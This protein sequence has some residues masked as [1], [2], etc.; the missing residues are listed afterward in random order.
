M[1]CH[2]SREHAALRLL[3]RWHTH[4]RGFRRV[5]GA[6]AS[7]AELRAPSAVPSGWTA[8]GPGGVSPLSHGGV[9]HASIGTRDSQSIPILPNLGE[10]GQQVHPPV[11]VRQ[12]WA[13]SALSLPACE[14]RPRVCGP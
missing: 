1:L 5:L 4:S 7:C 3:P 8:V 9:G 13:P 10:L 2:V 11:G 6:A 14:A 12:L